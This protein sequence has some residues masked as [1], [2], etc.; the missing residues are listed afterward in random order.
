MS[1]CT[2]CGHPVADDIQFCTNCGAR[3]KRSAISENTSPAPSIESKSV[4]P[5]NE[6]QRVGSVGDARQRHGRK[7][8]V[9][10]AS[11]VVVCSLVLLTGWHLKCKQKLASLREEAA[12][13][14]TEGKDLATK[15]RK[16]YN[17]IRN[18]AKEASKIVDD[19][20]NLCEMAAGVR[21]QMPEIVPGFPLASS[22]VPT[23]ETNTFKNRFFEMATNAIWKPSGELRNAFRISEQASAVG[24]VPFE[25]IP[26]TATESM[27]L[28]AIEERREIVDL[29]KEL[30]DEMVVLGLNAELALGNL[31]QQGHDLEHLYRLEKQSKSIS[32]SDDVVVELQ[33]IPGNLWFGKYEVTQAQWVAV[34]G[35]K[36]FSS[37]DGYDLNGP[38]KPA[39]MISWDECQEFLER[40]NALSSVKESGLTFRLPTEK[41][42]EFACRAGAKGKYFRLEDG[43]E[44]NE[45]TIS[46]VAW[47]D[48]F[49]RVNGSIEKVGQLQPNAFGLYDM[50]GNA[51]EWTSTESGDYWDKWII[52]G[53]GW[54]SPAEFCTAT[55]RSK[56]TSQSVEIGFR[57]CADSKT[58]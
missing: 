46:W 2:N 17:N 18:L 40:L 1:F 31:R 44:I 6:V 51:W 50:L 34:M 15:I 23:S 52:R 12:M 3:I 39:V 42:W 25:A 16:S 10:I 8:I 21:F 20:N 48:G 7:R 58:K 11:F 43:T 4:H 32:I 29:R 30:V 49:S 35:N 13:I 41:E 26:E 53:G 55:Y 45:Y 56:A 47:F 36:D 33:S 5:E 19:V 22:D 57:L 38:N 27:L 14:E 54:T 28:D 24:T 9:K 37:R